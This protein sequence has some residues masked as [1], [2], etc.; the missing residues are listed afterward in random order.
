MI[1]SEIELFVYT[2]EFIFIKLISIL[3][4]LQM[5]GSESTNVHSSSGTFRQEWAEKLHHFE[6]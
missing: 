4:Q 1:L 2:R 6:I 5:G 3:I